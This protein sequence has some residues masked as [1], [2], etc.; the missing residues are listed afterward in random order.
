MNLLFPDTALKTVHAA[1]T[2]MSIK[3]RAHATVALLIFTLSACL[4][5]GIIS[6]AFGFASIAGAADLL[7]SKDIIT[8]TTSGAA[9]Q[10]VETPDIKKA[11]IDQALKNAVAD[12]LEKVVERERVDVDPTSVETEIYSNAVD[13]IKNYKVLSEEQTVETIEAPVTEPATEE[14]SKKKSGAA[15]PQQLDVVTYHIWIEAV[16]DI[17]SLRAALGNIVI[18]DDEFAQSISLIVLDLPD[19]G[20]YRS[21]LASLERIIMIRSISYDSFTANRYAFTLK[22][23]GSINKLMRR[24]TEEVGPGYIVTGTKNRNIII[25]AEPATISFN[26]YLKSSN[27]ENNEE[28]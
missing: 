3:K 11:A 27:T 23:T 9:Q 16:I 12:V 7:G 4:L 26:Q 20:A 17:T 5:S 13:F 1:G 10:S 14:P 18:I 19:Y 8:V 6:T 25:K 28:E 24:I 2:A 15:A 21:L 22:P